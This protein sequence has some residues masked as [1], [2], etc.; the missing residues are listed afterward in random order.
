LTSNHG[1][2]KFVAKL[3]KSQ[4]LN[5]LRKI[6][7]SNCYLDHEC[8]AELFT[9]ENFSNI[10]HFDMSYNYMVKDE[11]VMLLADKPFCRSLTHLNMAK[12]NITIESLKAISDSKYLGNLVDLDISNNEKVD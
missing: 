2:D 8:L 5:K 10:T 3:A 1:I 7:L 11:G 6:S 9:S 12:C 4:T